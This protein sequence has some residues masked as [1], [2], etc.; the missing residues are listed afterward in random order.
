MSRSAA[1]PRKAWPFL[2]AMLRVSAIVELATG[3]ALLATPSVVIQAL[4]GSPSDQ[5]G[6]IV[7]RI[8]GGALLALGVA[9]MLTRGES[10]QRGVALAFIV[11][12]TSTAVVLAWAG[13]PARPTAGCSGRWSGST[14]SLRP[15]W[16][17]E[18]GYCLGQTASGLR[19]GEPR[20]SAV[21]EAFS[22]WVCRSAEQVAADVAASGGD[23]AEFVEVVHG[24]KVGWGQ[25]ARGPDAGGPER[26]DIG[27]QAL[28]EVVGRVLQRGPVAVGE[29]A[30]AQSNPSRGLLDGQG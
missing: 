16:P 2:A 28:H 7:A 1:Q 4:L 17:S 18:G 15:S 5:V 11:Y 23:L 14:R 20:S 22:S 12:N 10:P 19:S 13:A 25:L 26:H 21:A 6:W 27:E 9:G 30:E 3:C 8:L 29:I 24:G